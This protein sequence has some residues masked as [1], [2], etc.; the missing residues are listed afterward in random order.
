MRKTYALLLPFLLSTSVWAD[1]CCMND[2]AEMVN[3]TCGKCQHELEKVPTESW[4]NKEEARYD[5]VN[6]AWK[7]KY[8]AEQSTKSE[9]LLSKTPTESWSDD[10]MR[11]Y[12]AAVKEWEAANGR[13]FYAPLAENTPKWRNTHE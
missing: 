6:K 13:S 9:D 8:G 11:A 1:K 12:R 7:A 5:A 10:E 3:D 4:T 2:K